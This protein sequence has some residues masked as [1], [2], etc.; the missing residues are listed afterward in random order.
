MNYKTFYTLLG[1]VA[2]TSCTERNTI[3]RDDFEKNGF[4]RINLIETTI[5][6]GHR[7]SIIKVDDKEFFV[8]AD[9]GIQPLSNSDTMSDIAE[10]KK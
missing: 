9:G 2:F 10:S 7:L 4:S 1:A 8:N 6:N 3:S 5:I